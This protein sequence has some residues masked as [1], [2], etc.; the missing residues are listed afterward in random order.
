MKFS[1]YL[2]RRVFVMEKSGQSSQG[3][4]WIKKGAMFLLADNEDYDHT[5]RMRRLILVFVGCICQ[6][7]RFLVL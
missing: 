4:F 1:I 3:A 2:N 6:K 5:A 7:G